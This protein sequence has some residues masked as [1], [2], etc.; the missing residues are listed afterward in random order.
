MSERRKALSVLAMNTIAFTACF[1]VW[2]M[3]GVLVT[4]L[5]DSKVFAFDKAQMGWLIGIPV[6]TGALLRLPMGMLTD[7]FGGRPVFVSVMIASAP[8]ASCT[9]AGVR[10]TIR[11]R[12]SVSTAMWRLRP[13][14]FL[15]AS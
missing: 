15:A 11:S 1:A 6:L 2:M 8:A 4:F 5:V 14:T 13:F 10:F 9:S 3:N 12:P 7:R